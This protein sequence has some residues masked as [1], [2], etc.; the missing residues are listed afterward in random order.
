MSVGK[1]KATGLQLDPA[2]LLPSGVDGELAVTET[3]AELGREDVQAALSAAMAAT[4]V[5][6]A[7]L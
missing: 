5:A 6:D 4:A 3:D 1:E 7:T 2:E